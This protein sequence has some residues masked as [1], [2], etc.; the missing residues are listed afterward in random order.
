VRKLLLLI[1]IGLFGWEY[2]AKNY[3][4]IRQ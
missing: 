3:G 1:I 4:G 2:Y